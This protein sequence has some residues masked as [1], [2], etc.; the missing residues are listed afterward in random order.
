MNYPCLFASSGKSKEKQICSVAMQSLKRF[1]LQ[2]D[3]QL[4]VLKWQSQI[5]VRIL[6]SVGVF[7]K[8]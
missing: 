2:F 7:H 3:Q 8:F 4:S 1:N 5:Q 6:G